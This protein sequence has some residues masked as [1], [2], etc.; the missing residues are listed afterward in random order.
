MSGKVVSSTYRSIID[1]VVTHCRS[2]FDEMGIEQAVLDALQASWET[3]L[4]NTRVTDF[5][6]DAR[7]GPI[8]ASLGPALPRPEESA[9]DEPDG[10]SS[11]SDVKPQ[12]GSTPS[13]RTEKMD[14]DTDEINS[15]LD[16]SEDD[17]DAAEGEDA[18]NGGG[19]PSNNNPG[20]LVIALYDKVQRVKNK[21]KITLKD[22]IVSVQGKDYLFHKC[23]GEFEW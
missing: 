11:T 12:T 20:D 23:N 14:A 1:E 8:Q 5:S 13:K 7:L 4:A 21:W 15:D 2:E 3:K 10:P 9:R 22:G 19:G 18:E 16:D 17:V 6:A